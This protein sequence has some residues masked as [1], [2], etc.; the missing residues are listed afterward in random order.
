[1]ETMSANFD[2]TRHKVLFKGRVFAVTRDEVTLPSGRL[3]TRE[4]VR[5]RG[6]VTIVGMP[7]PTEVLLIRQYR[8][9]VGSDLW[10]LP[11]GTIEVGEPP[12]SC[13]LRELEEETGYRADS[14]RC[15]TRFYTSPGFCDE[16]MHVYLA[17]GCALSGN[18]SSDDD[19]DIAEVRIYSLDTAIKMVYD[20]SIRDAKTIV[21]LN[22]VATNFDQ[23]Q[24][25]GG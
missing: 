18:V 14:V 7:T 17:E 9:A 3:T 21:G 5:H 25:N 12:E 16:L 15:L 24:S 8:Y 10:E 4:V 22:L 1:M 20:G 2:D 13:A 23:R 6:S 19:E 11:A